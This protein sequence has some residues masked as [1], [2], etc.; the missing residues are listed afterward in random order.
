MTTAAPAG[1]SSGSASPDVLNL[2]V[3]VGE[4]LS[5]SSIPVNDAQRVMEEVSRAYGQ[6]SDISV[7]PTMVMA[8]SQASGA[9]RIRRMAQSYR[10]D[11]IAAAQKQIALA[12]KGAPDPAGITARLHAISSAAPSVRP[13]LRVVG[14]ALS[15]AGFA[16]YLR[17]APYAIVMAFLLGLAAGA[18]LLLLGRFSAIAALVPLILTFGAALSVDLLAGYFDMVDPIRLTAV[19]VITLLP[20]AALTAATIELVNGEM[21]SGASRLVYA[22]MILA[23]MGFAFIVAQRVAGIP[24]SQL[25]DLTSTQSPAWVAPIGAAAFGA[26]IM[27]F[28]CAPL[29]LRVVGTVV[30]LVAYGVLELTQGPLTATLACG[31][32][33][34]VGFLASWLVARR[35]S[36]GGAVAVVLFI[37]VFWLLVPGSAG[38]VAATGA[39]ERNISVGGVGGPI[40]LS[41][42]SIAIGVMVAST[43]TRAFDQR[44]GGSTPPS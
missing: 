38:F 44:H 21:I 39:I 25:S 8:Q 2:V 32:A 42:L 34:A 16:A 18:A 17:L 6:E 1:S 5:A 11:Q 13:W 3:A 7:L 10:F 37:P 36:A 40:L 41:L 19:V 14:Y 35:L 9:V 30:V 12:K 22:L 33:A 26:G 43:L 31:V 20:G 27:I 4:A 23:T 29:L 15:A 28:L 24:T